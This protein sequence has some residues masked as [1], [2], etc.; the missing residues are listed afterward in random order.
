M[1]RP[2]PAHFSVRAEAFSVWKTQQNQYFSE[3]GRVLDIGRRLKLVPLL[4]AKLFGEIPKAAS[5]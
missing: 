5:A 1:H 4:G 2:I 3:R